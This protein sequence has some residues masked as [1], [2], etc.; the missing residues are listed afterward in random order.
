MFKEWNEELKSEFQEY[1]D[2]SELPF[3]PHV[4][5]FRIRRVAKFLEMK[6]EID[7]IVRE[8]ISVLRSAPVFERV[9]IFQVHSGFRPQIHIE[10]P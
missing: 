10:L 6:D 2:D 5:L 4:T 7:A 3:T 9:S 1:L 8:E